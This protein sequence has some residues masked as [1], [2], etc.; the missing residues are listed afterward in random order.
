VLKWSNT[1]VGYVSLAINL[2][3]QTFQSLCWQN[4]EAGLFFGCIFQGEWF[5]SSSNLVIDLNVREFYMVS[6]GSLMP[7]SLFLS[8]GLNLQILNV[9]CVFYSSMGQISFVA[10]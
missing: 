10:S 2:F 8:G 5:F 6:L 3:I 4:L 9:I 7:G 1:L